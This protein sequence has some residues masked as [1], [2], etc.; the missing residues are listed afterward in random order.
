[1]KWICI[2]CTFLFAISCKP[3]TS[4]FSSPSPYE[5]YANKLEKADLKNTALGQKWFHAAAISK[6]NPV[7]IALPFT[8]QGFFAPDKPMATGYRFTIPRGQKLS[9]S[10]STIPDTSATILFAELYNASNNKRVSYLDTS[11]RLD[12]LPKE[13]IELILLVQPQ[14]LQPVSYTITFSIAPSLAFPVKGQNSA[15]IASVWGDDRDAGARRHEGID[16]FAKRGTPV[17]AV[18]HGF[19]SRVNENNLGGKVVWF[20]PESHNVSVYYAHLDSQLVSPGQKLQP[21][22]VVGLVGNTGNARTTP[23]HLHFGIYATGGAIDPYHFINTRIPEPS[24]IKDPVDFPL[25]LY[26]SASTIKNIAGPDEPV[27]IWGNSNEFYRVED[28]N[29]IQHL[30]GKKQLKQAKPMN[31]LALQPQTKIY[32]SPDSSSPVVKIIEEKITAPVIAVKNN[33]SFIKNNEM[34]GWISKPGR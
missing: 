23:P 15:A 2:Y 34:E 6:S 9:I 4:I 18:D 21:G 30:V 26:K 3:G 25:P 24:D 17:L 27:E 19:V 14:L 10:V 32:Y 22:D 5:Q 7:S 12:Y 33:Y 1:M 31:Q 8:E 29:G 13:T 20:Q 28:V 16:I 11:Y